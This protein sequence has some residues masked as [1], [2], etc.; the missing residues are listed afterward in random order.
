LADVRSA[1]RELAWQ[2]RQEDGCVLTD[3]WNLSVVAQL[4]AVAGAR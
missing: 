2:S 3:V 4:V 1:G